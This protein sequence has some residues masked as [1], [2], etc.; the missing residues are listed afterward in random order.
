MDTITTDSQALPAGT[1]L[2][3]FV[4][5]RV[6]GAGGFG[7]TYL[8]RDASLNR[9]VVIKE[10]LPAMFCFRDP[11]SM[12]VAPRHTHGDEAENFVWSL[13]N[14]SKEAAMLASLDH[15]GIVKVLRSFQAFGTA[16]FVMPYVEGLALD[17]LVKQRHG[18]PFTEAELRGL[19]ERVLSA[20]AYL[21]DR[22]IYHRDIKPGNLLIT[23]D[24]VPVLID[25]GS[26]RQRLSERSM[27]V[28]ESAGYT[29]FEQLQ[30]RGNVGPW[31]DLYALGATLEKILTG[32]APPKAADRVMGDPR[33]ELSGDPRWHGHYSVPFLRAIDKALSA[34]LEQRWQSGDEWLR[35]MKAPPSIPSPVFSSPVKGAGESIQPQYANATREEVVEQLYRAKPP[36]GKLSRAASNWL[37]VGACGL[38]V[39]FFTVL[40]I[41]NSV[42]SDRAEKGGIGT[43]ELAKPVSPFAAATIHPRAWKDM[44]ASGDPLAQALLGDA[45]FWGGQKK[46][47]VEEDPA[48][49]VKWITKSADAGHPLGLCLLGLVR[50]SGGKWLPIDKDLAK[51]NYAEAIRLGLVQDAENGG[52]VWWTGLA[53][54][55]ERGKGVSADPKTAVIWYRKAAEAGYVD[56]MNGLGK[57]YEEGTGVEKDE[58]IAVQWYRKAAA[59]G[60]A[61]SMLMLG[62]CYANGTGVEKNEATAVQWVRKSAEAGDATGMNYLGV[63][64]DNG[65]GVE[66]NEVEATKWYRKAAEAG[67]AEGMLNLGLCF[68]IGTDVEKNEATAVQWYRKAAEAG[69]AE[70]L[71]N[72]GL[73]YS[74]GTGVEKNEATAVQWYRK[75]AEAGD[76][77]G[78]NNL[79]SCYYNGTGIAKD[80]REAATWYR[81]AAEAGD[82]RGMV[83]LG[84]CYDNGTGI[85][86]DEREA[87]TWY[88]KAAEAGEARGMN[89]LGACYEY[90]TGVAKDEIVAVQWYRRA[91]EAG[92]TEGMLNLGDCYGNGAG[93]IKDEVAAAQWYRKAAEA[94]EAKGMVKLGRCYATGT[95]I[96]KDGAVAVQWFRKAAEAGEAEGMFFL[97]VSYR[98]GAGVVQD[99][100]AAAQWYRKAAEAGDAIAMSVLGVCYEYGTGVTKN[101][102]VA[103]QWYRKAAEAGNDSAIE[104]LKRLGK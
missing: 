29:P 50:E 97:G 10:N 61:S 40:A 94:G 102:A 95:G 36:S 71:N 99:E 78:M 56:G 63:C 91:A 53:Q 98:Y 49:G 67:D 100:V 19:L 46:H 32:D 69:D 93:V 51:R 37:I 15:P 33:K 18:Q 45:L 57:C 60:C 90:G 44:A 76:A 13:E 27:T 59:E 55:L 12:T 87:A 52:P 38:A 83:S 17:E 68:E 5:E 34:N 22:G 54:V 104:A 28:V 20:L 14:F 96:V 31:S 82:A 79:G 21:H 58:T 4:I 8:A 85:A 86:K 66:K 43:A 47:G 77:D 42:K 11:T 35:G 39:V 89:N 92:E 30:S 23:N 88:R 65:T 3:E 72:L 70:G 103:V 25:F 48:E 64:Y 26:A 24:G 2:E 81:K 16:Y 9:Q 80:E 62:I 1:R 6:L 7:I 73:C 75:A 41:L 101:E 74:N 84:L